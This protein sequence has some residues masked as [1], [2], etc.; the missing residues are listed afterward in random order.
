ML[1]SLNFMGLSTR[2]IVR[3][4]KVWYRYLAL[5]L[6]PDKHDPLVTGMTSEEAVDFLN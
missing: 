2:A 6:H 3:E 5:Q 1:G 4:V